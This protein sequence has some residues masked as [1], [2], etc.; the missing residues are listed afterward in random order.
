MA[1]MVEEE[2][3]TRG[4][5]PRRSQDEDGG[6]IR[7]VRHNFVLAII[8]FIYT[9]TFVGTPQI[10]NNA[11]VGDVSKDDRRMKPVSGAVIR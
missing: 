3:L 8:I 11:V 9:F 4:G 7:P 10:L 6:V 1:G 5:L 2:N